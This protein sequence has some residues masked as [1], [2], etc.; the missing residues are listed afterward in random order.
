MESAQHSSDI[1]MHKGLLDHPGRTENATEA[2]VIL[3]LSTARPAPKSGCAT[4]L[5]TRLVSSSWLKR[6]AP[7][8]IEA[9]G[10]IRRL[11][12]L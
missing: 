5:T 8:R 7:H 11:C 3:F 6:S 10:G 4:V 1:L 9:G 2:D 12:F